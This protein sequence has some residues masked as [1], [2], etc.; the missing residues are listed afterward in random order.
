[1]SI[2]DSGAIG[3]KPQSG[4]KLYVYTANDAFDTLVNLYTDESL[5]TSSTNP[6]VALGS[7]DDNR[8][9]LRFVSGTTKLQVR[10]TDSSDNVIY[11][12]TVGGG[13]T[14]PDAVAIN[15]AVQD[16][17]DQIAALNDRAFTENPIRNAGFIK[18]MGSQ[19]VLVN[20]TYNETI[21]PRWYGQRTGGGSATVVLGTTDDYCGTT[22]HYLEIQSS[23]VAADSKYFIRQRI[24]AGRAAAFVNRIN[25][26]SLNVR[27]TFG[28][29]V[30]YTLTA[31][32]ANAKDD[33][34]AVTQLVQ[35]SVT[36][37]NDTD[38]RISSDAL[39]YGDCDNGLEF[40]VEIFPGSAGVGSK[41]FV[42][43]DFAF[44]NSGVEIAYA[45]S[46]LDTEDQG[47]RGE[48]GAE[49][50]SWSI[51]YNPLEYGK[52]V[53]RSYDQTND[54]FYITH[55]A[56]Y[57]EYSG[58]I[59]GVD[60]PRWSR[61][62]S[63]QSWRMSILSSGWV[64][65]HAVA[66]PAGGAITWVTPFYLTD[67]GAWF[68]NAQSGTGIM[69]LNS[70]VYINDNASLTQ[71][72]TE[73]WSDE[74]S[75][76][77]ERTSDGESKIELHSD[78]SGVR[79]FGISRSS[80]AN[81]ET[82]FTHT[83]TASLIVE[84]PDG[85]PVHFNTYLEVDDDGATST[86]LTRIESDNVV[87]GKGKQSDGESYI[88]LIGDAATYTTYG[89]RL[90]R[91][92]G[93][94]GTSNLTH[95]GTGT[96]NITT[97]EAANIDFNV[98]SSIVAR[99]S[100]SSVA[101]FNPLS[102]NHDLDN[103]TGQCYMQSSYFQL[104]RSRTSDGDV[105]IDFATRSGVGGGYDYRISRAGGTNGATTHTHRGTGDLAFNANEAASGIKLQ[106]Q[107]TDRLEANDD[108]VKIGSGGIEIDELQFG[109]VAADGT[110]VKLPS[111]WSSSRLGAGHYRVTHNLGL[112]A[113]SSNFVGITPSGTTPTICSVVN[114]ANNFDVYID[115]NSGTSTNAA[116]SFSFAK[117]E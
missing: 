107:G 111:G 106:T 116:F 68:A 28:S 8:W 61:I 33:F 100:T 26:F 2:L 54:N 105:N 51:E 85:A 64:F 48:R 40:I 114:G 4:D 117:I 22:N 92:G 90:Q 53:A 81:S 98:D 89:L 11:S 15:D 29:D 7:G 52:L 59:P 83:G 58:F 60:S 108:G 75:I 34:S 20:G 79:T 13:F 25:I 31:N 14:I 57:G 32:K 84:C 38:T 91:S 110:A 71:G 6:V 24:E 82:T 97:H 65:E 47:V 37:E 39:N 69:R 62:D 94:N 74:V 42:M 101:V 95:R 115:G 30:T 86:G 16:I 67:E 102:L 76:G 78:T 35:T 87:V 18:T 19:H 36:V 9:P 73:I 113:P 44:D 5:S 66:G 93:T 50:Q 49:F 12:S 88:Y 45:H 23:T 1:M 55:N 104:G 72:R 17:L 46:H 80:G 70:I 27:H 99:M 63:A 96:L 103:A 109:V 41:V 21:F 3:Y 56:W 112:S 10:V 77:D 43:A